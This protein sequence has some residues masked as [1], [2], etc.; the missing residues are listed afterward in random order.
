MAQPPLTGNPFLLNLIQGLNRTDLQDINRA[1]MIFDAADNE[2]ARLERNLS[3]MASVFFRA[4]SANLNLNNDL[5][6]YT[7][8]MIRLWAELQDHLDS[9]RNQVDVPLLRMIQRLLESSSLMIADLSA[10]LAQ[11]PKYCRQNRV[12]MNRINPPTFEAFVEKYQ[13]LISS[14]RTK[15]YQIDTRCSIC[16]DN[17]VSVCIT[18]LC[19]RTCDQDH[20]PHCE[21]QPQICLDCLLNV[22]WTQT[23]HELRSTAPCP[24]CRSPFCLLDIV[25]IP[26]PPPAPSPKPAAKRRT[27]AK[28]TSSSKRIKK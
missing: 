4:I 3:P 15:G 11:L 19:Q 12:V 6:A 20:E 9:P 2:I 18:R 16:A 23:E 7:S 8:S 5:Q 26:H 24:I 10:M 28:K 22:F 14:L 1:M 21:C 17:A 13:P 25:P 27:Y